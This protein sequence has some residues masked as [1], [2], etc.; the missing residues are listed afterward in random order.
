M[1]RDWSALERG[2]AVSKKDKSQNP[3]F[4]KGESYDEAWKGMPEFVQ[5]EIEPFKTLY[6]HFENREDMEKFKKVI[7]QEFYL[8]TKS[9]WYPEATMNDF[10][11]V[12]YVHDTSKESDSDEDE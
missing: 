2:G 10:S 1:G 9:I 12:R 6:V 11:K 7:N 8:T 4:D 3:L 5:D